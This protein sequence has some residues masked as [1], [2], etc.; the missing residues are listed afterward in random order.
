[1]EKSKLPAASPSSMLPYEWGESKL[2]ELYHT[3]R[4]SKKKRKLSG[5]WSLK[6]RFA[7]DT[8]T[9]IGY[10]ISQH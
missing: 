8:G 6:Q 5:R 3:R 9:Y 4:D 2:A 1:M 10:V 7:P